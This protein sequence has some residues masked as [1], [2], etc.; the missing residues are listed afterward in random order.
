M[1][2]IFAAEVNKYKPPAAVTAYYAE[3][4]RDGA[5]ACLETAWWQ[6]L[7]ASAIAPP[8]PSAAA[9]AG[10]QWLLSWPSSSGNSYDPH[11]PHVH[12]QTTPLHFALGRLSPF[13]IE[14]MRRADAKRAVWAVYFG[15]ATSNGSYGMGVGQGGAIATVSGGTASAALHDFAAA[16]RAGAPSLGCRAPLPCELLRLRVANA[17]PPSCPAD[18]RRGHG[19]A[20]EPARA[21]PGGDGVAGRAH[22]AAGGAGAGRLPRR[23]VDRGEERELQGEVGQERQE[24]AGARAADRR[25]GLAHQRQGGGVRHVR[26]GAGARGEPDEGEGAAADVDLCSL[27]A[28][29]ELHAQLHSWDL[30]RFTVPSCQAKWRS[31][32]C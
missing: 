15:P 25:R 3:L 30:H 8:P 9:P 20:R 13:Y 12:R 32:S 4:D 11:T 6:A 18:L 2:K 23:G 5:R 31:T 10:K 22:A 7:R 28:L 21:R 24:A 16:A 27:L 19:A 29:V 14:R 17:A 26:G 1:P